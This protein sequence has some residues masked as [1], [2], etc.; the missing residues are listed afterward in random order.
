MKGNISAY[1]GEIVSMFEH[2]AE[3]NEINLQ[4]QSNVNSNIPFDPEKIETIITNLL[5]NAFKHTPKGG[6]ISVSIA[7]DK[8]LNDYLRITVKDTGK[9]IMKEDIDQ[10]FNRFYSVSEELND[11]TGAGSSGIGLSLVKEL[12]TLHKGKIS[13]ESAEGSGTSFIITLPAHKN[14]YNHAVVLELPSGHFDVKLYRDELVIADQ[15]TPNLSLKADYKI[16]IVEDNN[17]LRNFL[18][19]EI[20]K[21]AKVITASNGEEG[22]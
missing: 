1:I 4:L 13:V 19:S 14:A 5:T 3:N 16:L 6:M 10:I 15:L 7:A 18:K 11:S 21:Q 8:E 17:D 9:G 2:V 20:S 22:L 12:V